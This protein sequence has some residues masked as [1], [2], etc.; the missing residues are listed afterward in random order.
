[1]GAYVERENLVS[2]HLLAKLGLRRVKEFTYQ[3]RRL[4]R[5]LIQLN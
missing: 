3:G 5:Y 1:M 4:Y 2:L